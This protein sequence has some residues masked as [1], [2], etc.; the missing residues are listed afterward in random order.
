MNYYD[1]Y[2]SV[3]ET[4]HYNY[5]QQ[6]LSQQNH[7]LNHS[8]QSINQGTYQPHSYKL[9][10]R[11]ESQESYESNQGSKSSK[12]FQNPT[13]NPSSRK[14]VTSSFAE[15]VHYKGGKSRSPSRIYKTHSDLTK[16]E[17]EKSRLKKTATKG[18]FILIILSNITF[19][20]FLFSKTRIPIII[21]T[22]RIWINLK[23]RSLEKKLRTLKKSSKIIKM[24]YYM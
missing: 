6:P 9:I 15:N 13:P 21:T 2:R 10:E 22:K 4:T 24:I 12:K 20:N 16:K 3:P 23:M 18:L 11:D 1:P 19:E 17:K 8:V 5:H 7:N 14:L